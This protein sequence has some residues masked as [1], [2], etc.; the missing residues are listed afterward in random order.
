[1]L[2][3]LI[4]WAALLFGGFMLGRPQPGRDGRMPTWTRMASTCVLVAA[5][6]SWFAYA[7]GTSAAAYARLVAIGITL[8]F[9]ADLTMARLLPLSPRV[10]WGMVIF[11]LGHVAY[12]AA[13]LGAGSAYGLD[14][15]GP[16]LAAWLAW[17]LVAALAWYAV[18]FRGQR[19]SVLHWAALPYALLL[20]S[21]AGVATG[22]ALQHAA[23]A[24]LA[25]GAALFL[26][27]DLILAAQLFA[28]RRF[29]LIDDVIWLTY[30]PGQMLIVYSVA[31]AL[32]VA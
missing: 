32:A 18:V 19:P 25:A 11:G 22:L 16:R 4:L 6:W 21:T 28:G 24:P 29:H 30:G 5:G 23:F 7:R 27:S 20:A 1:M 17:L 31:A 13:L 9:I 3:L 26:I 10:L 2:I 12:I 15:T 8:G 14:A